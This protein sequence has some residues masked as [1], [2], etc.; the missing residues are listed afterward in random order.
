MFGYKYRY[1]QRCGCFSAANI[2]H[3]RLISFIICNL[4]FTKLTKHPHLLHT[5]NFV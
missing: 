2:L 3:N 1:W 4:E 5:I